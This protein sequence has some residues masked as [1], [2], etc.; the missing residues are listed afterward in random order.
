MEVV[1][2]QPDHML[3]SEDY[4]QDH[5]GQDSRIVV[6]DIALDRRA[7]NLQ[8]PGVTNSLAHIYAELRVP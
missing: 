7:R 3:V 6:M 4:K 8:D 1:T 5:E 2:R